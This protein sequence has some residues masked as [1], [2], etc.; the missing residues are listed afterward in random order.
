MDT[1]SREIDYFMQLH[2]VRRFFDIV[3]K[4][5]DT[6]SRQRGD[7]AAMKTKTETM[8]AS[9]DAFTRAYLITA[10]WSSTGDDGEP[11]DRD[12]GLEDLAPEAV[13][14]AKRDCARFQTENAETLAAAI[15]SGEV[16]CGPDFDETGRAGHDFWLTR[17]GH[18][19][20]FWEGDWPEDAG[21]KL[22][23]ASKHFGEVDA[24]KGDDGAIYFS[25]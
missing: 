19:A 13:E 10:L 22:T 2:G 9:L 14:S 12:H 20:G 25:Q 3:K 24:Y 5:V 8:L 15:E 11:L 23:A 6:D 21:E 16:K 18:G 1:V 7:C 4:S 17:N